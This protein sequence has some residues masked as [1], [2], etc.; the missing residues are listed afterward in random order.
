MFFKLNIPYK[1]GDV[2]VSPKRINMYWKKTLTAAYIASAALVQTNSDGTTS[3]ITMVSNIGQGVT[4]PATMQ[5]NLLQA[6]PVWPSDKTPTA[7]YIKLTLTGVT[8]YAQIKVFGFD[9]TWGN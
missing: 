1:Y 5:T 9:V 2:D 6:I 3:T 4:A 7:R 8:D